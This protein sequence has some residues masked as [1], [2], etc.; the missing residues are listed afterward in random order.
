MDFKTKLTNFIG[1]QKINWLMESCSTEYWILYEYF[2]S[3]VED[4]LKSPGKK[5]LCPK[6]IYLNNEYC[7]RYVYTQ[8]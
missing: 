5:S 8:S 2:Q 7:I 1:K 4:Y 3:I 6:N